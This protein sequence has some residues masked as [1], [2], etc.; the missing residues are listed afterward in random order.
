MNLQDGLTWDDPMN[1]KPDIF[2]FHVIALIIRIGLEPSDRR[3]ASAG[4]GLI[5]FMNMCLLK[6]EGLSLR[7]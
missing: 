1:G 7:L 4:L 5:I 3:K 6:R 2:S